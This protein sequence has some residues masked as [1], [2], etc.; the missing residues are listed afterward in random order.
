MKIANIEPPPPSVEANYKPVVAVIFA[1]VL[2]VAG[3]YS[4][5]K[6]S[7]ALVRTR[8]REFIIS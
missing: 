4:S 7:L 3:A 1:I 5:K 8:K 6:R 2:A